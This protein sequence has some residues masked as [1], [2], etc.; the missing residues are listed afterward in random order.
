MEDHTTICV[1]GYD[2]FRLADDQPCPE[3]GQIKI[4]EP[5]GGRIRSLFQGKPSPTAIVSAIFSL[6]TLALSAI[7]TIVILVM[8]VSLA[9]SSGFGAPIGLILPAYG[10]FLI[11]LPAV[12]ISGLIAIIPTR[13]RHWPLA[14]FSLIIVTVSAI[15]PVITFF[16]GLLF[17]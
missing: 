17:I 4:A 10:Y 11:I 5:R 13:G 8:M 15:I 6:I 3:C 1:C 16:V 2:R 14:V 7:L 12:G 9:N